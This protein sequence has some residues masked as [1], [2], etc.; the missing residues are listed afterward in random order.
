VTTT[1]S[2][3]ANLSQYSLV[4]F[5]SIGTDAV[6]PVATD[7]AYLTPD[8]LMAY[9]ESRLRSIDGQIQRGMDKQ[10]KNN[11]EQQ[12]IGEL[13]TTLQGY[14]ANGT[15]QSG[16]TAN[17]KNDGQCIQIEQTFDDVIAKIKIIDPTSPLI[18]QLEKIHDNIMATG[19]Q[20]PGLHTFY[21]TPDGSIN[22]D[23][24]IDAQEIGTFI[25]DLQSAN[26]SVNS[27]SELG[28]IQLQSFMSQRQTA[29]Q[30]TTN[31]VQSLGDQL[32]KIADN[33]GH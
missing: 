29:I 16:S 1:V 8:A 21:G 2:S 19:T 22:S 4:S 18:P 31:L 26:S 30:L 28:M 3:N 12:L 27:S 14:A 13:N 10:N 15:T 7:A 11:A 24:Q 33:I 20:A 6:D 25:N 17:A 32:N 5:D 23:G 9:C